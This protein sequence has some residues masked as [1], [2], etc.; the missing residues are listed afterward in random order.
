LD[1]IRL[2]AIVQL[3][4]HS[5]GHPVTD[6]FGS[7]LDHA[8]L[9]EQNA[10]GGVPAGND[11]QIL[12]RV[13]NKYRGGLILEAGLDGPFYLV[14]D[15]VDGIEDLIERAYDTTGEFLDHVGLGRRMIWSDMSILAQF[16]EG[17]LQVRVEFVR[18]ELQ[19]I[20]NEVIG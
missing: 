16:V 4:V 6:E 14:A 5:S 13:S 8:G 12:N 9:V 1:G 17:V 7:N 18:I 11:V 19:R 10:L 15:I 20:S 2:A 3:H